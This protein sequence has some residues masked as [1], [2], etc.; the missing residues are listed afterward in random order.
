LK[1]NSPAATAA[2]TI[3]DVTTTTTRTATPTIFSKGDPRGWK[4]GHENQFNLSFWVEKEF[5]Q[6]LDD[7]RKGSDMSRQ[8]F[9]K[10][11][12]KNG[13]DRIDEERRRSGYS[14]NED[15]SNSRIRK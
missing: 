1:K 5:R 6:R 14:K 11:L 13:L 2:T 15:V 7:A 4:T 3:E 9:M 12:M 8:R 10:M